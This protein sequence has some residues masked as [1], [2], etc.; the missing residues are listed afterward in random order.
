MFIVSS[1]IIYYTNFVFMSFFF[2]GFLGWVRETL[3]CVARAGMMRRRPKSTFVC[4]SSVV[5]RSHVCKGPSMGPPSGWLKT[6]LTRKV[7]LWLRSRC[8]ECERCHTFALWASISPEPCQQASSPRIVST[9]RTCTVWARYSRCTHTHYI[10][11]TWDNKNRTLENAEYLDGLS[12][13]YA[14]SCS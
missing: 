13:T 3:C 11:K 1:Y 6:N 7:S 14:G 12:T 5:S 10:S 8:R 9:T 4:N 2:F